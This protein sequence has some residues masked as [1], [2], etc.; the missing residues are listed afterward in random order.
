MKLRP[1][2]QILKEG[3]TIHPKTVK[4]P[5]SYN[6][7]VLK[8]AGNNRK[9]GNG[10][11]L[12]TKGKWA[13]MPMFSL[14]LEERATCPTSCHH[15]AD[16]YGNGMNFATR[17]QAGK[18]LED[19]LKIEVAKLAKDY[20]KGFVIRLHVL[21]DFYSIEYAELWESFLK[22]YPNLHVFG[23]TA[24]HAGFIGHCIEMLNILYRN[25]FWV[26][27]SHKDSLYSMAAVEIPNRLSITCPQQTGKTKACVTCGLCW[28]VN[29]PI[30][31]I[32]H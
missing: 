23:Y 7:N 5:A 30:H 15:W 4:D 10:Q 21:G 26:R 29:K 28:S 8:P 20:P 13:G 32:S 16:C 12:I 25:R 24:R 31:F 9:L 6:G 18:A 17:F 3:R 11:D 1:D 22:Q 27:S 2:N 19:K 14:T